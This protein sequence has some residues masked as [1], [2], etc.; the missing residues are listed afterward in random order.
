M[1]RFIGTASA[2]VLLTSIATA[3][4]NLSGVTV[5]DFV[6]ERR[7]V[8][9]FGSSTFSATMP[10]GTD[11]AIGPQVISGAG[12]HFAEIEFSPLVSGPF[13]EF[14][15][16]STCAVPMGA[17]S[18]GGSGYGASVF[19]GSV[20]LTLISPDAVFGTLTAT[21]VHP[22]SSGTLST[23]DIGDD[24]APEWESDPSP[25]MSYPDPRIETF[26]FTLAPNVPL[27]VRVTLSPTGIFFTESL[28]GPITRINSMQLR[29]DVDTTCTV[30][31]LGASC[32]P[33]LDAT[34]GFDL[35]GNLD[36]S[37]TGAAAGTQAAALFGFAPLQAVLPL[38]PGCTL[39]TTV[40][41]SALMSPDGGGG[42]RLPIPVTQPSLQFQT[43][44][45]VVDIGAG[46]VVLSEALGLHYF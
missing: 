18:S 15:T 8:N 2:A 4:L 13:A 31:S 24:G 14:F 42:F 20:L 28:T 35:S 41:V 43:Q 36:L 33:A 39:W 23:I 40:D 7:I 44:F 22:D 6:V 38:P 32:D 30:T 19:I 11:L 3:Q 10:A 9:T 37:L 12:S 21:E 29:F 45:G 46:T 17:S 34:V 27:D 26:P 25:F 5:S 1:L 16:I